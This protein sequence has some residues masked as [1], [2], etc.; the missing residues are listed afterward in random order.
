MGAWTPETEP[1]NTGGGAV[2]WYVARGGTDAVSTGA[3]GDRSG[4]PQSDPFPRLRPVAGT[5]PSRPVS[6]CLPIPG[7]KLRRVQSGPRPEPGAVGT[8]RDEEAA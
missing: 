6:A 1:T 7:P 2:T 8:T 4:H 5:G 3:V